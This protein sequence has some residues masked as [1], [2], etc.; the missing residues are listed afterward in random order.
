MRTMIVLF[1]AGCSGEAGHNLS[2][3]EV[4]AQ[5]VAPLPTSPDDPAWARAPMH[6]AR[7]ILQDLVEPRLMKP[8]TG[9]IAVQALSNGQ[10][11]LFRLSWEDATKNELPGA[12]RF[13]DA[14]ALQLPQKTEADLPAPQMG[15]PGKPVEITYWSASFQGIVDGRPED[16][17]ALYP[18][19]KVDHY[20][21]E[22]AAI[23]PG[24]PEQEAMAKRYAPAR[25]AGNPNALPHSKPVQD[26]IAEGPGTL[27]PAGTSVSD[28]KGRHDGK[29]WTV[30]ISRPLPNGV[31]PG[32]RTQIAFAVW[33]GAENEVGARKMR[34]PWIP[35]AIGR[36]P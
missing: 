10:R 12:A 17:H 20:P 23:E 29:R 26:L 13:S 27:R 28:G 8:S 33:Q 15:Q 34:T 7:L 5:A 35:L 36:A 22:A 31:A 21:F 4:S 1:L 19:A 14:C 18:N 30:L 25:A 11:L 32:G 3:S 16:I 9:E 24:S 2:P 6:P